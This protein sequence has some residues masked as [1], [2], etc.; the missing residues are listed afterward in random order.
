MFYVVT[1]WEQSQFLLDGVLLYGY[2]IYMNTTPKFSETVAKILNDRRL[3][4]GYSYRALAE[5]TTLAHTS[6][7]RYLSA[8]RDIPIPCFEEIAR[9]LGL[10]PSRVLRQAEEALG[11][12]GSSV[13]ESGEPAREAISSMPSVGVDPNNPFYVA[14]TQER[15]ARVLRSD[16]VP[17]AKHHTEEN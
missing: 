11:V 2:D 12:W 14:Q 15:L 5:K 7:Q 13:G 3:Q 6:V 1:I 16:Y 17:A 10:T 8:E 9:A 4:L